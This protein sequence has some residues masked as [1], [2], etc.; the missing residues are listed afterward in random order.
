MADEK[1]LRALLRFGLDKK[2][3]EE[4]KA[5]ALS[6]EGAV[7]K[8]GEQSDQVGDKT[9]RAGRKAKKALSEAEEQAK[10]TTQRF[11]ELREAADKVGNIAAPVAAVGTGVIFAYVQAAQ[12]YATKIGNA[13]VASQNFLAV[14]KQIEIQQM[15]L[16]RSAA[17]ALTP[18]LDKL[19]DL[20][21]WAAD[22][23]EKN[24]GGV[25]AL[26]TGGAAAAGLGTAALIGAQAVKI[27]ADFKML[28]AANLQN[29]AADKML[30]AAGIQAGASGKGGA[31]GMPLPL[32]T[33][34]LAGV[35]AGVTVNNALADAGVQNVQVG[36][37][38][39]TLLSLINPFT[40]AANAF[41]RSQGTEG[42]IGFA[43]PSQYATVG[44]YGIGS[45]F[46]QQTGYEW[47]NAVGEL[48]GAFDNLAKSVTATSAALDVNPPTSPNALDAHERGGF[49][50]FR[51]AAATAGEDSKLRDTALQAYIAYRKQEAEATQEY[52]ST[53][54]AIIKQAGQAIV[55]SEQQYKK[56]R[57][58]EIKDFTKQQAAALADFNRG[59][60][61]EARDW[62]RTEG[63]ILSDF[64]SNRAKAAEDFIRG[65]GET[66]STY[67]ADRA[68]RAKSFGLEMARLE[69]D[70]QRQ[71]R[72]LTE[73]HQ[74]RMFD[75]A[76]ERDALG[77]VREMR[78]YERSRRQSEEEHAVE[79]S[80]RDS[81][82][83]DEFIANEARF[84]AER[85]QRQADFDQRLADQ[86]EQFNAEKRQRDEDR[87]QRLNDQ[88]EDYN[89]Q[90][91]K[92]KELHDQTL[93]NMKESHGEELKQIER[94]RSERL[95][96][97]DQQFYA[98]QSRR[99]AAFAD[100]IRMLDASLLGERSVKQAYYQAMQADFTNWLQGMRGSLQSTLPGYGGSNSSNSVSA[101]GSNG[102][103]YFSTVGG[104][105]AMGGY[106]SYGRYLLGD[107]P[108]GGPGGREFVLNAKSTRLAERFMRGPLDQD[109]MLALMARGATG[110]SDN[111]GSRSITI[112]DQRS[113]NGPLNADDRSWIRREA[114]LQAD[115]MLVEAIEE[116]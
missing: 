29:V 26:L 59:R 42:M 81:D 114:R 69:E 97:L 75:L 30:Q 40:T 67:Y 103:N 39:T 93:A 7:K 64:N 85:E 76:A 8:I 94:Q 47:A 113:F 19:G 49:A 13:E 102:G 87:Q 77:L 53:R 32:W 15:R 36:K 43:S 78:D 31:P 45:I 80:R 111:G 55:E 109:K 1:V 92:A 83:G 106:A 88:L 84:A 46:G 38:L 44:A 101:G 98:E 5:G 25:Q 63:R 48:T 16:G 65:E 23:A 91:A 68:E 116:L 62:A 10:R 50:D 22:W 41:S 21:R 51:A 86:Q 6:V 9:E 96:E 33:A 115:T 95:T 79:V 27:A 58:Q 2:S 20:S 34:P 110:R 24:P 90:R 73:D 54:A 60:I 70:H 82:F 35:A 66:E 3:L 28:T 89:L 37:L 4:V 112:T 61:R 105:R 99:A 56:A 18:W 52:E 14:S 72:N 11:R 12:S 17:V 108:G 74:V 104:R 107:A 71:I 57:V 100:S